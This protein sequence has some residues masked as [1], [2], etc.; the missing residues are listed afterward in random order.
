MAFFSEGGLRKLTLY[1]ALPVVSD[2]T[3]NLKMN[4][5]IVGGSLLGASFLKFVISM[6]PLLSVIMVK[7]TLWFR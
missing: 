4:T 6:Y 5:N 1:D 3:I 2:T 7:T